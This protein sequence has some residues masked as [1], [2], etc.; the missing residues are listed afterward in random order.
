MQY[1]YYSIIIYYNDWYKH[2]TNFT[3]KNL[4][5]GPGNQHTDEEYDILSL[6]TILIIIIINK[7][8]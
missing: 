8:H 2:L 6:L 1:A 7:I 4:K 3:K 5:I